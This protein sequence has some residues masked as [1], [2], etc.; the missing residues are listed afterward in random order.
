MISFLGS[1]VGRGHPFYMDGVVAAL[2]AEGRSDLIATRT[3]VFEV[4]RGYA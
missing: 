3:D 1:E 2:E 4:S